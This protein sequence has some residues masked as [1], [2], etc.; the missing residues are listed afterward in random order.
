MVSKIESVLLPAQ[1]TGMNQRVSCS[2]SAIKIVVPETGDLIYARPKVVGAPN[3]LPDG[4]YEVAFGGRSLAVERR[5][6][7]WVGTE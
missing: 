3:D 6:G 5:R 7:V 1:L 4:A 2:V